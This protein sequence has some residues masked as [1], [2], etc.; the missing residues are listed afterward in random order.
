V[1]Y[2]EASEAKK[3]FRAM[4]FKKF[5]HLPLYLEM[6]PAALFTTAATTKGVVKAPVTDSYSTPDDVEES[7]S[8]TIYVK[9]CM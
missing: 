7:E 4:A 3:A 8:A 9:N 1:E 2:I 6:A 5:K